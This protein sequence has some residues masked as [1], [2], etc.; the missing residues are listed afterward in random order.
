ML[1]QNRYGRSNP[2][3]TVLSLG[4][5][6]WHPVQLHKNNMRTVGEIDTNSDNLYIG[7]ENTAYRITLKLVDSPLLL[8]RCHSAH[9]LDRKESSEPFVQF[10][11]HVTMVREHNDFFASGL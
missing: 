1:H 7:Q 8:Q 6:G 11:N 4:N 9:H 2:P 10:R 5:V 3:G